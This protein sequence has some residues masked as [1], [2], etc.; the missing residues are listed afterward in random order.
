M[1]RV[2]LPLVSCLLLAAAAAQA[3]T[4]AT[5]VARESVTHIDH[6]GGFAIVGSQGEDGSLLPV[7]AL[8]PTALGLANSH[9]N[10]G[11]YLDWDV[12][13]THQ[14]RLAQDWALDATARSFGAWGSTQ[15]VTGGTVIGPNCAPCLPTLQ[16]DGIN[17]QALD[18][19]VDAST[20]YQ[21][22]SETTPGQW[23]DLLRWNTISNAWTPVW[24]G[25]GLNQGKAWTRDGTLQAGLY[26]LRN[27]RD[28]VRASSAVLVYESEW[29]WTMTLPDATVSAVPEPGSAGLL[30]ASGLWL[31]W[32]R[33]RAL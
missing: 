20:R 5:L 9:H 28:D 16:I 32:R 23:V 7:T 21:F 25:A 10:E 33:R 30:V 12:Q 31:A 8:R 4:N 29:N 18:F 14:W 15:L 3:Q 26:R 11:S 13:Y 22:S 1:S 24:I 17:W 19:E 27:A 6:Y 2:S